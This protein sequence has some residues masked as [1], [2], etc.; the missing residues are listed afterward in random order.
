MESV[1][2]LVVGAGPT[3]M[4]AAIELKRMG[5]PVRLIERSAEPST[6]SRALV[7]QART[8]ELFA[9]RGK[10]QPM[11]DKG[12]P[13]QKV[14]VFGDGRQLFQMDFSHNGSDFPYMLMIPQSETEQLL[15]DELAKL[16]VAIEREVEYVA[17][18]VG[19]HGAPVTATLRHKDG[20]VEEVCCDY[21]VDCEGAHS[22]TR[23]TLGLEFE[24]K[25]RNE[26]YVLGDVHIDG[27]PSEHELTIFS[28]EHG[29]MGM[30]PMQGG[31][32]RLIASHPKHEPK[33]GTEPTLEEIQ[34]IYDERSQIKGRFHD[35]VWSSYFR[36]NSRMIHK[37]Q[38]GRMFLGGDAAH[39]HSPAGG[40][41]M[42]TGIQDMINL[43]W[44]LAMVIAGK[45][46][47]A[48]L[49]TYTEDRVPV[50]QG[51]LEGTEGLTDVIGT[52]AGLSR[53]ALEHFA[54]FLVG[55]DLV[56][57]NA[58]MRMSQVLFDYRKS[59]LSKT[60]HAGGSLHAGDR[61]PNLPVM[62][63]S[64][65]GAAEPAKLQALIRTDVMT[66]LVVAGAESAALTEKLGAWKDQLAM[67]QV[68]A[69]EDSTDG[70]TDFFGSKPSL[71]LV[72]PDGYAAFVGGDDSA[73]QFVDYLS[74]W[75]PT[76]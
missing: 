29:F 31:R 47:P 38:K 53:F 45:A 75:F 57:G 46:A 70:F 41:G 72:R 15:R 32:F 56:Q 65:A 14:T 20:G 76:A 9:Q 28:S 61:V 19:D 24:G 35:M 4:T 8:L 33:P 67:V 21:L 55:T 52:Q 5:V 22:I 6:T 62:Q 13:A 71:V 42:N 25:T 1:K 59:P 48:L 49:D 64:G 37:L 68:V 7:V 36:I 39:I 30:F 74:T 18:G 40:Q 58:T 66:L 10:V 23:T 43:G 16:G 12:N 17:L 44:K 73:S 27:G 3:G 54:P 50:I 11:L 26:S 63:T 51:V 69:A 60:V 34:A 2:V